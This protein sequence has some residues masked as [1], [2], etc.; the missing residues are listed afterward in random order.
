M[1]SE[2]KRF[3]KLFLVS[4]YLD[5][6]IQRN[7]KER[8]TQL[9][10]YDK[11]ELAVGYLKSNAENHDNLMKPKLKITDDNALKKIPSYSPCYSSVST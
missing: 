10:K 9:E 11:V 7:L 2:S 6:R 5:T 4:K 8:K 3:N 1:S